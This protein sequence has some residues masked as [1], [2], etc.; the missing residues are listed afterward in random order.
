VSYHRE[1]EWNEPPSP[2]ERRYAR[3]T[4]VRA[5]GPPATSWWP[6]ARIGAVDLYLAPPGSERAAPT[7]SITPLIAGKRG[8]RGSG[9]YAGVDGDVQTERFDDVAGPDAPPRPY[10]FPP[11]AIDSDAIRVAVIDV[12][13]ERVA[14]LPASVEGPMRVGLPGDDDEF[15]RDGNPRRVARARSGHRSFAAMDPSRPKPSRDGLRS[16][17]PSFVHAI[18][19]RP[20]IVAPGHGTAMAGVVLAQCPGARVGLFQIPGMAEAARPYLAPADLAAAVAAAVGTWHADVVLIA[21]SDGAWGTPSY[22]RDVLREAARYGRRGRGASIFCSVGDPSRNHA[23]EDDSAT[24]G[25]DDLASQPWVH[26]IAACDGQGRWYRVYPSYACPGPANGNAGN[27]ATYNRLG[28]AIALAALGE[29]RRWSE[30]IA[31]DDS[32]QASA[33]AAAAAA[34][35]LQQNRDLS[36]VELRALLALTADVPGDVDGGRGLAAGAFDARDRLGHNFKIGHGVVNTPAACL[37]AADPICLALLATRAVPDV[38]SSPDAGDPS[39]A[40]ALARGWQAGVRRAAR[41]RNPLAREYLRLAGRVSRLFLTSLPVQEALCWLA[42]HVRALA[43]TGRWSF[44]QGQHHGALVERIRHACET[45]RDA[46]GPDDGAVAA[47]LER[48]ETALAGPDAGVRVATF[49]ATALCPAQMA[50]DGGQGEPRRAPLASDAV[51]DRH[52]RRRPHGAD[53]A[54]L[55][56]RD[57]VARPRVSRPV[58][59]S[60]R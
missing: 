35:V 57:P 51:G 59:R 8:R 58:H 13:F 42:R 30:H 37:G 40:V 38:A 49:L 16:A 52:R 36:A 20:A 31:S 53:R 43:E 14:A 54:G 41:R 33:V 25:A 46:L 19:A 50:P 39:P 47:G 5:V 1:L 18:S 23:R 27:G 26:A 24:L 4:V 22:L 28:P 2:D 3:W 56:E 29:P 10:P 17:K 11:V 48:V 45:I 44:W 21:M 6:L 7:L 34:R 12:S 60:P 32:S 9:D 55:R 15:D